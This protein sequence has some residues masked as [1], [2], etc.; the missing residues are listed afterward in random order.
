MQRSFV[1]LLGG[2]SLISIDSL[3]ARVEKP[4]RYAGGEYGAH[5][6]RKN[7]RMLRFA[8]AFPDTYEVGM[9]HLGMKIIYELINAQ[10]DMSCERVF[11]PWQDMEALMREHG[12]PLFALES[13]DA[14]AEFDVLGFTLQYEMSYTNILLM[15]DLAGLPLR[16]ADRTCGPLVIAGG[17]CALNPEPIAP[18]IDAIALGDGEEVTLEIC[19][20]VMANKERGG[21]RDELLLTLAGIPGI[22]VPRF[23]VD[24]KPTREDVPP[25]I[26]RRIVTDLNAAFFP[27]RLVVPFGEIVH[28]RIMLEVARGCSRGCRFCQAGMIYRPVRER[29]AEDLIERAKRLVEYTGYEEIS[30]SSLS[31]GDYTNLKSLASG[32]SKQLRSKRVNLSF[33]SLRIDSELKEALGDAADVRKAG[34]TFAPEAGTQRLRDAI[35]KGVSEQ[36]LMDAASDAFSAGWSSVKL[37]FMIGLPT[38]TMED[39]EG[40]AHLARKVTEL[41]RKVT[42]GE[43]RKPLSLTVSASS[44]VPKPFTPF[45]WSGQNTQEELREK[46]TRLRGLLKMKGVNFSWHEPPLSMLEAAFARGGRELAPVLERAFELGCRFDGWQDRFKLG[47]W[48][49]AF[50]EIGLSAQECASRVLGMNEPLPWDHLDA[51][52]SKQF[53][54]R[55]YERAM[56]AELTRDCRGVCNG[57]GLS[58]VCGKEAL[59]CG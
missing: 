46:Q 1:S 21:S 41:Y 14:I 47:L 12:V 40:I 30:L 10:P 6:A 45:Q 26:K 53:L 20:A 42:S 27:E 4:S 44:F 36:D 48:L 43:K 57:C 39:V 23:Y 13:R 31:T 5:Q 54:R 29:K 7:G 11:A 34:L 19:R 17:P 49:K 3:L 24:G 2:N 55:E 9:S 50:D 8:F 38:E 28:D 18:F 56:D 59:P 22:Y 52:V 15:L 51:G 35:N 25:V 33:P 58:D 37:Y 32:L 16:S